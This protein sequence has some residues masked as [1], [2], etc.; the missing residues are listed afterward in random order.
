[1]LAIELKRGSWSSRRQLFSWQSREVVVLAAALEVGVLDDGA[2]AGVG[3]ELDGLAEELVEDKMV[4]DDEVVLE[5]EDVKVEVELELVVMTEEVQWKQ[6]NWYAT[7]WSYRS[8]RNRSLLNR[9]S[10]NMQLSEASSVGKK[11]EPQPTVLAQAAAQSSRVDT[12]EEPIPEVG[13]WSDPDWPQMS[14][15]GGK[16]SLVQVVVG[17]ELVEGR[18]VEDDKVVLEVDIL[19]AKHIGWPG[20]MLVQSELIFGFK[21]CNSAT[22]IPSRMARILQSPKPISSKNVVLEQAGVEVASAGRTK[23]RAA[24]RRGFLNP[25]FI[26]LY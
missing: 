16:A 18:V 19:P 20:D 6:P 11:K 4:E 1:V 21:A 5:V 26:I 8:S 7:E 15:T 24:R 13:I 22:V 10:N 25:I 23:E 3:L 9:P 2:A 12:E 14:A 17:T